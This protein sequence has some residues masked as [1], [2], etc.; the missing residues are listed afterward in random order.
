MP[1][2][3]LSADFADHKAGSIVELSNDEYADALKACAV[4][5]TYPGPVAGVR[6]PRKAAAP[7]PDPTD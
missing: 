2:V 6:K 7:K 4:R 3:R 5:K 1:F